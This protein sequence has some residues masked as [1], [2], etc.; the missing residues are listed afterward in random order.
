MNSTW[1][2]RILNIDWPFKMAAR[3]MEMSSSGWY[4]IE[5]SEKNYSK[6][7]KIIFRSFSRNLPTRPF[8]C[9]ESTLVTDPEDGESAKDPCL[10]SF[11]CF[12]SVSHRSFA[13]VYSSHLCLKLP[14]DVESN[15]R[16]LWQNSL[17][18]QRKH[19]SDTEWVHNPTKLSFNIVRDRLKWLI[20]ANSVFSALFLTPR[21][22]SPG[23]VSC[24]FLF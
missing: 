23:L 24:W 14:H 18:F 19:L 13:C 7:V 16:R 22:I 17:C 15:L 10:L 8:S 2:S 6:A 20:L 5:K 4:A 3:Y 21:A 12:L 9:N 11:T 1:P